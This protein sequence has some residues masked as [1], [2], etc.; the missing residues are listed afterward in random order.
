MKTR[1]FT[2]KPTMELVIEERN[3]NGLDVQFVDTDNEVYK[4]FQFQLN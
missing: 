3:D 4:K 2:V 1:N